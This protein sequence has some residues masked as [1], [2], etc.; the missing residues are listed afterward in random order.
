M[1]GP[2]N[3]LRL[4][5]LLA[6]SRRC[7]L[8]DR[9]PQLK[10]RRRL[11]IGLSD[12]LELNGADLFGPGASPSISRAAAER[13]RCRAPEN[14]FAFA[15]NPLTE[16]AE[17]FP[18]GEFIRETLAARGLDATRSGRDHG[19]ASTPHQRA[20]RRQ[21]AQYYSGHRHRPAGRPYT[22]APV[23]TLS[24]GGGSSRRPTSACL[25]SACAVFWE[26]PV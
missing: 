15:N 12:L 19:P 11:W 26:S 23:K 10:R 14:E 13:T 25:R 6:C 9:R 17:A 2:A 3:Q 4:N 24:G 21:A 8:D 16:G 7:R 5:Q 20:D 18:P 1:S 22:E